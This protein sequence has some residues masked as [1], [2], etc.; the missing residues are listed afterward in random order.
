MEMTKTIYLEP[1][2]SVVGR[3]ILHYY[4]CQI[5]LAQKDIILLSK[6]SLVV[7]SAGKKTS[8]PS[9]ES[10]NL[11]YQTAPTQLMILM[12]RSRYQS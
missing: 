8:V 7:Y 9:T 11:P 10:I 12:K 1:L 3:S 4:S 2:K 6:V 5:G